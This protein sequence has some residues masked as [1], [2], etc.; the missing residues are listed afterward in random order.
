MAKRKKRDEITLSDKQML[1]PLNIE[2]F[3]SD[4]DPCFGKLYNLTTP[5]CK[6]C[7]DSEI[8][9]IVY[10]QKMNITRDNI[11]SKERFKD[12]ELENDNGASVYIAKLQ[13]KGYKKSKIVR[14]TKK[15]FNMSRE[16]VK[17]LL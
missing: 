1:K 2:E 14:L 4:K 9:A 5:E 13:D 12:I 6:R 3:G 15:K 11:E 17:D 7:G 10:A 8:C 16:D